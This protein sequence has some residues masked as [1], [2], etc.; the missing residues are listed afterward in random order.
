MGNEMATINLTISKQLEKRCCDYCKRWFPLEA[1]GFL[2]G[3]MVGDAVHVDEVWTPSDE[4]A[5]EC[6]KKTSIFFKPDW[7]QEIEELAEEEGLMLLGD[8]HS[9][10]YRNT[11]P[12]GE[13]TQSSYDIDM[14]GNH[15]IYGVINVEE[16]LTGRLRTRLRWWGP[17][18]KVRVK[19]TK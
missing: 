19:R 17:S 16:S 12:V 8:F 7:V 18:V 13:P 11:E 3:T 1:Y 5:Q 2:L 4:D 15:A 9:H 10:P 6:F 14:A